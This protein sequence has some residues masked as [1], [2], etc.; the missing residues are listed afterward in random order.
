MPPGYYLDPVAPE[1]T[2][3]MP[4][5]LFFM[6]R[7]TATTVVPSMKITLP[8]GTIDHFLA[9]AIDPKNARHIPTIGGD[10]LHIKNIRSVW[11]DIQDEMMIEGL[12]LQHAIQ[13]IKDNWEI[14]GELV[15]RGQHLLVYENHG[16]FLEHFDNGIPKE[17]SNAF[18]N[19]PGRK[20]TA[21][22]YLNSAGKDFDGGEL[23]FKYIKN[24]NGEPLT[25][26]PE[27]GTLIVFPG[28]Y[29]YMHEVKEVTNGRR[30]L[31]SSWLGSQW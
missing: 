7:P 6:Y 26:K 24:V 31:I 14:E 29:Y 16:Q 23:I 12:I 28:N 22:Y 19:A 17:G 25:I 8:D 13:L 11:L 21:L 5:D 10:S 15:V 2:A 20:F 27:A 9:W 3:T 4:D 30:I 18:I 1:T